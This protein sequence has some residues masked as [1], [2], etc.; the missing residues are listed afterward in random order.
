M[1]PLFEGLPVLIVKAWSDVTQKL[2]DATILSF[3][4]R[5]FSYEKLTLDYWRRLFNSTAA[6][7]IGPEPSIP[8]IEGLGG[9]QEFNHKDSHDQIILTPEAITLHSLTE[10]CDTLISINGDISRAGPKEETNLMIGYDQII[11][12]PEA[13]T[14][15]SLT[16]S[17]DTLVSITGDISRAGPKEET[18]L[19]IGYD[20][21][22]LTPEAITMHSLTESRDTLISISGD[23]SRAGP[24]AETN[25]M[26][27]YNSMGA[28]GL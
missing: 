27:G 10:S 28:T 4:N 14:L 11:L 18:N 12:T 3:R 7:E 17:R 6:A 16:E 19:M 25:L 26:I 1:D 21:I 20:Q 23:I 15:H 2:L 9:G 22:I 8:C 24:K 5:K 13:I